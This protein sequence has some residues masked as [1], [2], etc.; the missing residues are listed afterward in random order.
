MTLI[1][2][3]ALLAG[4]FWLGW[5][6]SRWATKP[7]YPRNLYLFLAIALCGAIGSV[8]GAGIWYEKTHVNI[9]ESD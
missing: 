1:L 6:L 8:A 5:Q 3:I 2:V 7:W 9:G 4:L